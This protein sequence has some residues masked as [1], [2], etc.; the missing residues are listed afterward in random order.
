MKRFALCVLVLLAV[1]PALLA[2][3]EAQYKGK[4]EPEL[5]LSPDMGMLLLSPAT[6][7]DLAQLP[8]KLKEGE[9]AFAGKLVLSRKNKIEATLLLVEPREGTP[10][11]YADQ[12][13]NAKLDADERFAF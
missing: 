6:E 4:L 9:Q 2:R 7:A 3:Q 1:A 11:V 5:K 10:F 13:L 12:N 8:A